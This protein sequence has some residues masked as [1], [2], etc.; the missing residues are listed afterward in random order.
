MLDDL[1]CKPILYQDDIRNNNVGN[2]LVGDNSNVGNVLSKECLNE[3]GLRCFYYE[4]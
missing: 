3:T 1:V 4:E 2:V